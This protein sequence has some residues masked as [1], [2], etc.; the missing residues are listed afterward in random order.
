MDLAVRT[1]GQCTA[2]MQALAIENEV[3]LELLKVTATGTTEEKII[4]DT[5]KRLACLAESLNIPFSLKTVMVTQIK[6]INEDMF[7]IEDGEIVTIYSP[8]VLSHLVGQPDCLEALI[9]V[10]KNLNPCVMVVTEY[11][12]NHSCPIFMER[13]SEALSFYGS[14]FDYFEDSMEQSDQNRFA[15]EASYFSRGIKNIVA[16]EDDKRIFR[17]MK[18]DDWR[19]CLTKFELVETEL[20]LSSLYQAELVPKQ[21]ASGNCC[22]CY[23]NGE[24]LT[25]NWKGAPILSLS[26]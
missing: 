12:A 17:D 21:L 14:P 5:G 15:F 8:L 3:P 20:G 25:M 7:E 9:R 6:D 19:N 24:S 4:D 22:T 2:L 18:I 10:L 23:R 26:A 16:E 13:F 11:E 1:G